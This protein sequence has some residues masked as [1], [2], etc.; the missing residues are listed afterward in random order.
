MAN[1]TSNALIG[2]KKQRKPTILIVDDEKTNVEVLTRF[3]NREGYDTAASCNGREAL[4]AISRSV[5]DLILLDVIMPVMD[6]LAVCQK[7]RMDFMTRSIPIIFLSARNELEDRLKGLR[8]GVDD[9]MG[10]PFELEEV[11]VRLESAL[12]RRQWDL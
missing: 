4:E 6:G 10:K 8:A 7:L 5:P 1:Q 3:M 11:K 2:V 12:T 9:Y